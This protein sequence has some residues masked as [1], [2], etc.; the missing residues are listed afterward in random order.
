[1][2]NYDYKNIVSKTE[3][4]A[5]KELIFNRARQR[6]E[7]MAQNAQN[8]YKNSFREELMDVAR[9]SFSSPGNPFGV[10]STLGEKSQTASSKETKQVGFTQKKSS[11][12]IKEIIKA[13]NTSTSEYIAQNEIYGIM[14]GA[15]AD[16]EKSKNFTGALNFLNAHAR[17]ALAGRQKPSFEML[18]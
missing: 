3:S 13:K 14:N 4:E 17:I 2:Y 12:E 7:A 1:M 10:N 6:A 11:N 16:F 5:L 15:S 18:A 8:E 9:S